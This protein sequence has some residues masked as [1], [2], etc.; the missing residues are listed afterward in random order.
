[1][2]TPSRYRIGT[3]GERDILTSVPPE[4]LVK[5]IALVPSK[6]YL[7]L[8]HTTKALRNFI[9]LNASS[10]CNEA[11]W[12]RFPVEAKVLQSEPEAGWLVPTHEKVA[13]EE[14][15]VRQGLHL[16]TPYKNEQGFSLLGKLPTETTV[17][18]K[19]TSPG[20]QYLHFLEGNILQLFT[21]AEI[22]KFSF[23]A[24]NG[25]PAARVWIEELHEVVVDGR[26]FFFDFH[27]PPGWDREPF[28]SFMRS[29]N[30]RW[31]EVKNGE[32]VR[33]DDCWTGTRF[34]RELVWF[35]GIERLRIVKE[36]EVADWETL[37]MLLWQ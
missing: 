4:I 5:I 18:I 9:K 37:P 13:E 28:F 27:H 19:I 8:V 3:S 10:I 30:Q 15:R 7:D 23:I 34:P 35:Y 17:S 26:K 1:M 32:L 12:T 33:H 31:V 2:S 36:G 6:H 24:D 16:I 14:E 21:Q 25:W 22:G 11:I 29:F 20:P